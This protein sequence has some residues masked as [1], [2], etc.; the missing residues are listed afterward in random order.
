MRDPDA[1]IRFDPER[2]VR[3]LREPLGQDHFLRSALARRW[4][5]GGSIV[6]FEETGEREVASPRLPF[7]TYPS[8]W[9]DAQL[10]AA[11]RLTLDLQKE[12][13]AAGFDLKDASAWNVLFDGAQPFFCDLL[14]FVPLSSRRWWALGQFARHFL[15]PLLISRYRGIRGHQAF[16]A[17]RDGMPSDVASL[18]MGTRRFLTR[19]W[20][21]MAGARHNISA[22]EL[23]A[24][25]GP[26][27]ADA[28]AVVRF[29]ELLHASLDW[30]LAGLAPKARTH[31]T[32]SWG[33]YRSERSH[34]KEEAVS[35]KRTKISRWLGELKPQWVADLGCN[36]GEF[37]FMAVDAGASVVAIDSDHDSV[38][39]M[40]LAAG[41]TKQLFPVLA[42]LDDLTGARGWGGAEFRGLGERMNGRFDL[43]M[44]L[45]LVHHLA[46]AASV[47]LDAIASFARTC[48]RRWLIIEF[49]D[50]ADP[51]MQ[52]LCTRHQRNTEEFSVERQREAF[53]RAGFT[54][55]DQ[56]HLDNDTRVLSLLRTRP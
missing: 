53:L 24:S 29:R 35:S 33:A 43:V 8:E 18:A 37:S 23:R 21:L 13:V 41:A 56:V 11:A 51:Q 31:R 42:S 9:C 48:S 32:G 34:Y 38:D 30:W 44:M 46:V 52:L 27:N 25:A 14:S 47:P 36:S 26:D 6:H 54:L 45:A 55:H 40:F 3:T 19:Y 16:Q 10:F 4:V 1:T 28:A 50:P 5:D 2:V 17:W 15:F 7:V 12:A 20:P 39:A 49:I 22:A